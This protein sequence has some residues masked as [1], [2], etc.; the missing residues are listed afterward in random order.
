VTVIGPAIA[1]MVNLAGPQLVLI[2]G[3]GVA[4]YDLYD[5]RLRDAFAEHAFG[6]AASCEIVTRPHTFED[7]ARGASAAVIRALVTQ[8]YRPA[9]GVTSSMS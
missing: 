3:E 7:W 6:T 4:D 9:P 8:R 5:R 2:C 1:T